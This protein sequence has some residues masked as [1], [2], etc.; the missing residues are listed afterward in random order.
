MCPLAVKT[1]RSHGYLCSHLKLVVLV[2][3][4]EDSAVLVSAITISANVTASFVVKKIAAVK[5]SAGFIW[6][7]SM[8]P[9]DGADVVVVV[10]L[11][12]VFRLSNCNADCGCLFP[13]LHIHIR[14]KA[15]SGVRPFET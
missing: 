13:V 2:T 3:D 14:I 12:T 7:L 1:S 10:L 15:S 4:G 11:E 6:P 5:L 9:Y 8:D